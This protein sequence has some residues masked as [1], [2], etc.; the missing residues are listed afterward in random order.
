MTLPPHIPTSIG[1][2]LDAPWSEVRNHREGWRGATASL[3]A[4]ELDIVDHHMRLAVEHLAMARMIAR[5][6]SQ[7]EQA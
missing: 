1:F 5:R 3:D 2:F 6:W 4:P 7:K